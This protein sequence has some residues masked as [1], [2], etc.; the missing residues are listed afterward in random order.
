[1][2]RSCRE[3]ID[4]SNIPHDVTVFKHINSHGFFKF[5]LNETKDLNLVPMFRGFKPL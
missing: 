2:N 5:I 4:S 1:M 3:V